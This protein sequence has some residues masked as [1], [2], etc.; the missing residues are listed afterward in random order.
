[1]KSDKCL[2]CNGDR[3]ESLSLIREEVDVYLHYNTLVVE[4]QTTNSWG[5]VDKKI[6]YC[7]MCGRKLEEAE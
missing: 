1:M 7:P 4:Y 2:Y 6:N 3:N 5:D